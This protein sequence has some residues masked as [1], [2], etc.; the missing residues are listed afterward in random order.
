MTTREVALSPYK[1]NI[2]GFDVLGGRQWCLPGSRVW[3][4]RGKEVEVVWVMALQT[5]PTL[6]HSKLNCVP[7]YAL[8]SAA[9]WGI[10]TL[11]DKQ[12][13]RVLHTWFSVLPTPE[14]IQSDNGSQFT[15]P[16]VKDWAQG[17]GIKWVFHMLLLSPSQW[18][19]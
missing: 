1:G 10:T 5:S 12:T 11:P 18:D 4:F 16:L 13:V 3:N 15:A 9:E 14:S 8:P 6:P 17:E 2:L 19:C 7:Q